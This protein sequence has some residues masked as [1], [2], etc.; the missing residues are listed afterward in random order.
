[1]ELL[2]SF[3]FLF[4]LHKYIFSVER[5][6]HLCI[7]IT[8]QQS[9]T[10]E[11]IFSSIAEPVFFLSSFSY[12][13]CGKAFLIVY[14]YIYIGSPVDHCILNILLRYEYVDHAKLG[15]GKFKFY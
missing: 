8:L 5:Y 2:L 15:L 3:D 14:I 10:I 13:S 6:V 1:M 7:C 4:F 11:M 9:V 12:Y